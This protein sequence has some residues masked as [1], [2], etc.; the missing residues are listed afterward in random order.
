[1]IKWLKNLL[2]IGPV[3]PHDT[4]SVEEYKDH[5]DKLK[6]SGCI[7]EVKVENADKLQTGKVVMDHT[8]VDDKPKKKKTTAKKKATVDLDSMKKDELL[9]YAKKNGVKANASMK[10]ADILAAINNS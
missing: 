2:G 4:M 6:N 10:K 1:M 9:A 5:A 3:V 7:P 8:I